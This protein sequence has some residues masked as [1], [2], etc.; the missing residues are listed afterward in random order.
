MMATTDLK[1]PIIRKDI[2]ALWD[3]FDK[4]MEDMGYN[5]RVFNGERGLTDGTKAYKDDL[6]APMVRFLIFL[7]DPRRPKRYTFSIEIIDR[8]GDR[9]LNGKGIGYI[10]FSEYTKE[11]LDQAIDF[12]VD[13][14]GKYNEDNT[15]P[16]KFEK[17]EITF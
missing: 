10:R 3:Y 8:N 13:T 2:V 12:I 5:L 6:Y 16:T 14:F 17:I 4:R 11:K 15:V 7:T 9:I 1:L